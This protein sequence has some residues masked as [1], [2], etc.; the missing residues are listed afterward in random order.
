M[1][2]KFI[3]SKI[4]TVSLVL[5]ATIFSSGCNKTDANIALAKLVGMKVLD[6][7]LDEANQSPSK[8]FFTAKHTGTLWTFVESAPNSAVRFAVVSEEEYNRLSNRKTNNTLWKNYQAAE[9][10]VEAVVEAGKDYYLIVESKN[11]VSF[12]ES[13]VKI[14]SYFFNDK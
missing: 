9:Q 14:Q 5:A 2:F 11:R 3:T 13:N 4:F 8:A 7:P 1:S 6:Q 12:N 10:F